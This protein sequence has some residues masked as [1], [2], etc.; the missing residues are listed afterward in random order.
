MA[1]EL[2]LDRYVDAVEEVL[3]ETLDFVRGLDAEQAAL[4]TDC[5]GW[6]VS[7]N[8]AHMVGLEQVLAG[9]PEPAVDVPD[10]DHVRNEIG[11]YMETHVQARRGL[12]L[13]V[14]ADELAGFLPR[15]V[16]QLR[17]LAAGGDQPVAG[18]FG[19]RPLSA[20]LPIRVVDLWAHEQDIRHA[21]G[22]QART[23]GSA[24]GLVIGRT[25]SAWSSG[26]P[27]RIDADATLRFIVDEPSAS[28]TEIVIGDGGPT[29][30]ISAGVDVLTRL[31]FGRGDPTDVLAGARV[32]GP[33]EM[34]DAVVHHL[35]FTP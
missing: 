15:R 34:R 2:D 7:D 6:T 16:E 25:L 32:E 9:S 1:Y 3:T 5:P 14:V 4:G 30:E 27:D 20:S 13:Q 22:E 17:A 33:D 12:P 23:T 28:T 18:P 35:A 29:L 11:R 8:L 21:V 24:A 26:L 31:G 19:E 10:L